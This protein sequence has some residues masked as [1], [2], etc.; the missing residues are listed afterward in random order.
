MVCRHVSASLL[1]QTCLCRP[2]V[3]LRARMILRLMT[4]LSMMCVVVWI[5]VIV[6]KCW[7]GLVS[8]GTSQ[9]RHLKDY[10][11]MLPFILVV[12]VLMVDA[13]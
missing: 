3:P 6:P 1:S 10:V 12:L 7:A 11:I 13:Y 2:M 9:A 4:K 5:V 8:V